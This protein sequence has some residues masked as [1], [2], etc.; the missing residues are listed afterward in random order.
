MRARA[1]TQ[2]NDH[3]PKGPLHDQIKQL[4]PWFHNLHLPDGTQTCPSHWLGDF[5]S[6]KWQQI[7]PHIPSDLSGWHCLDIGC[8]AGFYSFELAKRR[9]TV[10][11]IDVDDH[12]LAQARWAAERFEVED[13]VSFERVQIYDLAHR[14]GDF[15]LVL[16]MGV[17]YHLRYPMLGLDIVA[18]K[19]KRLMLFQTLAMP[20]EEVYPAGFN[21]QWPERELMCE[22]G[23]PK[24]AFIEHRF[25]GD[26]TNWW[27]PNHAGI[28]AMLRSAGMRVVGRPGDEMYLCEPD[29]QRPSCVATW[30]AAELKSATG[31]FW[32]SDA[33]QTRDPKRSE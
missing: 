22:R 32:L 24:M 27:V 11:G 19:V 31:Q 6:F 2:L 16:F 13:R 12:Y 21:H 5:P 9:A 15:D 20:G 3:P 10:L 30:N 8:N 14:P 1:M 33:P 4:G 29:P 7:A 18:Q 23:W 26:P 25:A 28:E 17:F